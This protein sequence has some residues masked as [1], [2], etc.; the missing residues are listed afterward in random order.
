MSQGYFEPASGAPGLADAR[1]ALGVGGE[2]RTLL[3]TQLFWVLAGAIIVYAAAF[4]INTTLWL[5]CALTLPLV[6]TIVGGEKAYPVLV[7]VVGM[8]WIQIAADLIGAD[9]NRIA[10]DDGLMGTY[11]VQA[12]LFS[13]I[14]LVAM[15]IGMRIGVRTIA[16][17]PR[18]AADQA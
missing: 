10:V 1:K 6:V 9:V 18:M 17:P 4:S 16:R 12:I 11:Q 7:W 5:A 15:A 8:Y 13:L 14:A 3:S 2:T